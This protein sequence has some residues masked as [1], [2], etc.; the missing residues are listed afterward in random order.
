MEGGEEKYI[1]KR[2]K[3][4]ERT[5]KKICVSGGGEKRNASKR[6][7]GQQGRQGK[8]VSSD[9]DKRLMLLIK[10]AR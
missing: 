5:K 4:K 7:N 8:A 10:K 2:E 9:E 6:L 1:E 3:E